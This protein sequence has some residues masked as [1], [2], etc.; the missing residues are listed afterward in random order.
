MSLNWH[1]IGNRIEEERKKMPLPTWMTWKTWKTGIGKGKA[2]FVS[3]AELGEMICQEMGI[4][5]TDTYRKKVIAWEK[6]KGK[7]AD[8][9]E[10]LALCKIFHCDI[11]YLLC[12]M[13]TRHYADMDDVEKYGL[14]AKALSTLREMTFSGM[15]FH[16]HMISALIQ[17]R[18]L[19]DSLTDLWLS[20]HEDLFHKPPEGLAWFRDGEIKRKEFEMYKSLVD[21]IEGKGS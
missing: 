9:E 7:L 13:D 14:T 6:G 18:Y 17:N 8:V 12:E 21:F 4:M 3:Q 20:T 5:Y 15:G 16:S 19:I 1:K 11:N 2:S 10:L